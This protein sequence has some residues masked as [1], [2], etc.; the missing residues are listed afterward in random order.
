M[1]KEMNAATHTGVDNISNVVT[2]SRSRR[3]KGATKSISSTEVHRFTGNA[4]D[5]LLKTLEEPPDH[6]VFVLATTEIDKVPATIKS[7][8]L[9]FE[10]R[11]S[12]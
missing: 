9:Q 10:F 4:F 7:R 3:E 1:Q 5:A 11:L 8:C 2:R 6:A 12:P